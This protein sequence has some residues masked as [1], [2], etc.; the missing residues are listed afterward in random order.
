MDFRGLSESGSDYF[1]NHANARSTSHS[2]NTNV[3]YKEKYQ[4]Q[5][6]PS[7]LSAMGLYIAAIEEMIGGYC[8]TDDNQLPVNAYLH[9]NNNIGEKKLH[10]IFSSYLNEFASNLPKEDQFVLADSKGNNED[11]PT[12]LLT[13]IFILWLVNQNPSFKPKELFDDRLLSK[14][15]NYQ[16]CIRYLR[17]FFDT[18]LQSEDE[19][20]IDILLKPSILHPNDLQKQ[21]EYMLK[22]WK[23]L[24]SDLTIRLL[25]SMDFIKEDQEKIFDPGPGPVQI[26]DFSDDSNPL[27]NKYSRDEDWMS[28]LVLIAKNTYVWLDQLRKQYK[29]DINKLDQ[30]PDEELDLL[31]DRGITGLWFIG[32]WERSRASAKIK[33]L[34]GNPEA[35][36]SAYSISRYEIADDLGGMQAY[37]NLKERAMKK[38]IR[39]GCDMVPNHT[40]IDS[41]WVSQHPDWFISLPES[42]YPTYSFNGFNLSNY[43][44]VEIY[45]EDHYYDKTDAAVVFK[46]VETDSGQTSYI[47]HGND[48]TSMPWNDTAQLNYL[49]SDVREAILNKIVSIAKEFPIIRF[50]AAMTLTK[51][52]FQRL[53]F[54][55]PGKGGDIPTRSEHGMGPC[56]IQ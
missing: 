21:L 33:Q 54:P 17:N 26:P 1:L 41:D 49:T 35:L 42:P 13:R 53:W 19:N 28:N 44:G 36:S 10:P 27:P 29:R 2:I 7:T 5:I 40:S 46:R 32:I 30:I 37:Q 55:K 3:L 56:R 12:L 38:G 14:R 39:V 48:G 15:Y 34:C 9:V 18:E 11:I 4:E 16:I 20:L 50:D 8:S 25:R 45:L 47:Y 51:K 22:N 31:A 52:H 23:Y 24:K 43:N 6:K